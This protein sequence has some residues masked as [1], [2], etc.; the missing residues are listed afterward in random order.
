M[1][2]KTVVSYVTDDGSH[3]SSEQAAKNHAETVINENNMMNNSLSLLKQLSEE[4]KNAPIEY[5]SKTKLG[6][7]R[8]SDDP[9]TDY[10]GRVNIQLRALQILVNQILKNEYTIEH[11]LVRH[12]NYR[13]PSVISKID[14]SELVM[15]KHEDMRKIVTNQIKGERK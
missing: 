13:L 14:G 9:R 3:F 8:F 11:I 12:T 4:L 7:M 1:N 2:I 10:T 6:E 5:M 15:N